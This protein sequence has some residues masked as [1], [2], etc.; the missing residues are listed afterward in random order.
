M[1]LFIPLVKKANSKIYDL[2][3]TAIMGSS[4]DFFYAGEHFKVK[5]QSRTGAI[6]FM[7]MCVVAIP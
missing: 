6:E 5:S 3:R 4:Q 1:R 7:D 2:I